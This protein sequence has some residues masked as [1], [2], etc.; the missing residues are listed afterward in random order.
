MVLG[1]I[2]FIMKLIS[3]EKYQN[4]RNILLHPLTY[5]YSPVSGPDVAHF[6]DSE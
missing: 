2:N 6:P 1:C 5:K 4:Q 3:K